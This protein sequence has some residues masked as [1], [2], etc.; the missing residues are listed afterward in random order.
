MPPTAP[1]RLRGRTRRLLLAAA[2]PAALAATALPA[3]AQASVIDVSGNTYEYRGDPG[4]DNSLVVSEAPDGSRIFSDSVPLRLD[5]A[6]PTGRFADPEAMCR[7]STT[8][9]V[10]CHPRL[11]LLRIETR[12]G[13]DT[14]FYKHSIGTGID[15]GPGND[16]VFG[17]V[18]VN[19]VPLPVDL[20]NVQGGAGVDTLTFRAAASPASVSAGEADAG[21]EG[22]LVLGGFE[23][24]R[25][26]DTLV[27]SDATHVERFRGLA[28]NDRISGLGGPDVFDEGAFANGADT[29]NGG[30]GLDLVDYGQRTNRIDVSLSNVT[31]D[32]GETGEGDLVDPNVNS[33]TTGVGDDSLVG[34]AGFNELSGGA[35]RDSI[36]AGDG[37]DRVTGGSE[38]DILLA[39]GGADTVLANDGNP[40][41]IRCGAGTDAVT[42]DLADFDV[43]ACES[44]TLVGRLAVKPRSLRAEAGEV[45]RLRLAWT[46][47]RA[48]R[49]L[50]EITVRLRDAQAVVAEIAI[51]P[52]RRRAA[53]AD[54]ALAELIGRRVRVARAGRTVSASLPL[55]IDRTLAGR[56]LAVE[57]E[58]TDAAG[59]RQLETG[60]AS[61]RVGA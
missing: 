20:H 24:T 17:G 58:A 23:G 55:R 22:V 34:S 39:E 54:E 48:W 37:D 35:G 9:K 18:R 25:F 40:D 61:I 50:R 28:G 16:T 3:A 29:F 41:T 30:G 33:V 27:G 45:A 21:S 19:P 2:L 7:R 1:A 11:T 32:D 15:A 46:H 8:T 38:P 43:A 36:R 49:E 5:Q 59:N 42:R 26:D 13:E 57:V 52:K 14:V 60:A 4:E 44:Q 10:I 31:R 6:E 12:D 51:D 53:A 47:P 56:R